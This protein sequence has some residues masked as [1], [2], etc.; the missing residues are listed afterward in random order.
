[1]TVLVRDT[2]FVP[3]DWPHAYVPVTAVSRAPDPGR[4]LGV[5]VSDAALAPQ[6]WDRLCAVLDRAGLIRI[7]LRDFGD[8]KAC[9][10]AR[11]LRLHGFA[12]R[13]R[14]H[15]AVL[16]RNYTLYRRAGFDEVELSRDQAQRQAAE[17]WRLL[18]G[19]DAG[20]GTPFLAPIW[21]GQG[22]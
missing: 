17:H 1:M 16:A 11:G 2:G 15:G 8:A 19:R 18:P 4:L 13:L 14:A 22:R 7:G 3:D 9:D 5:D 10:L 20:T 6:I 12:G 21:P